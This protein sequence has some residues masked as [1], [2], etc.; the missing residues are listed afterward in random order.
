MSNPK[1][2][3]TMRSLVEAANNAKKPTKAKPVGDNENISKKAESF[4]YGIESELSRASHG[5]VRCMHSVDPMGNTIEFH[6]FTDV[7]KF[8]V[9]I[10]NSFKAVGFV[11]QASVVVVND[12]TAPMDIDDFRIVGETYAALSQQLRVILHNLNRY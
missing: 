12:P 6:I 5:A 1:D 11:W 9:T 4:A 10:R 7:G 2:T 3:K 8:K